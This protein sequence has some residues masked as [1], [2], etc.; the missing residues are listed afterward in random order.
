MLQDLRFALRMLRSHRWFSLA[1][2]VTLALGIGVNTTV[3]TLVNAVLFKPVPV[4][5]GARLVTVM[6][7]DLTKPD[8]RRPLSY[9][10][11]I[12]LRRNNHSFEGLDAAT[13]LQAVIS[14]AAN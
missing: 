8:N 5:G 1:V 9:P 11:F 12:E 13:G 6:N 14:E 2:V 4:P 3:F 10:D 7:Q